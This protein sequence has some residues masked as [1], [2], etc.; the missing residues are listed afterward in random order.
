MA[1]NEARDKLNDLQ[2][3][4]NQTESQKELYFKSQQRIQS[5]KSQ[6]IT[7]TNE[8]NRL[9]E[10]QLI[11]QDVHQEKANIEKKHVQ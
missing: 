10:Q 4:T 6:I 5:M 7:L 9:K 11:Y 3:N 8:L 2:K 1:L